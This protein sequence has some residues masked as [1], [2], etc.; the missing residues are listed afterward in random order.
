MSHVEVNELAA[1]PSAYSNG[2]RLV[3]P[4]SLR[5]PDFDLATA[6]AVEAQLTK[7]RRESGRTTVGRKVGYAS[8]A[9]WR[10]LKLDTLVWAR[11]YD[12]TVTYAENGSASL[13]LAGMCSPRIE[14][15]IVF[16]LNKAILGDTPGAA[17]IDG[18]S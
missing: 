3:V 4:P 2:G 16:K 18:W 7:L 13:S 10:R 14:P 9:L 17:V 5:D 8:K 11:M 1:D 12:D 6:Y 15:E